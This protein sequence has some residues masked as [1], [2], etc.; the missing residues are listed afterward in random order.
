MINIRL[1]ELETV[2]FDVCMLYLND[3]YR[4]YKKSIV[5]LKQPREEK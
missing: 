5:K 3:F 1:N 4:R 2:T